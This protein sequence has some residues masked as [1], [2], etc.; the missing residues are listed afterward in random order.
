MY[1]HRNAS[2]RR[3]DSLKSIVDR[4][5]P[6]QFRV[7]LT[8]SRSTLKLMVFSQHGEEAI[9]NTPC[10]YEVGKPYRQKTPSTKGLRMAVPIIAP[11]ADHIT[12]M[13]INSET[14]AKSRLKKYLERERD[15]MFA[16]GLPS[17]PLFCKGGKAVLQADN[18]VEVSESIIIQSQDLW[19]VALGI[20][21]EKRL[22]VINWILG[23]GSFQFCD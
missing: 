9:P 6:R 2:L 8:E 10:L 7:E 22:R 12:G 18:T 23:V 5:L 4:D 15:L 19:E 21:K 17:G 13:T 3:A 20:G 11:P 14:L 16:D 1:A